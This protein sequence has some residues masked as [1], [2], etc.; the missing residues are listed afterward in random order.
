MVIRNSEDIPDRWSLE[1]V[2]AR[3]H[4]SRV[5]MS[6]PKYFEVRDIKNEFMRGQLGRVDRNAAYAQ[7]NEMRRTFE[8]CGVSCDTVAALPGCE[9]MVFT[10]NPSFNGRTADGRQ[11][12]VLSRMAFPSRAPEVAAHREW[13]EGHGYTIAEMPPEVQ[14]FE[15]GGDAV[16]HPGRALIWVGAGQRTDPRA[17][18]ALAE[19]FDASVVSL[20]LVDSRFYHLD[21]CFCALSERCALIYPKAF[22]PEGRALIARL[23]ED[24]I[25]ID[26]DEATRAFACNATA[27]HG[28]VVVMQSGATRTA[29]AVRQRGF[30]VVEV[31]TGE[32]LKSGGSV[33]CMKA[34]LF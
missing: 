5:L 31:E 14:R 18:Q 25:E 29:D 2:P 30:E 24:V 4:A 21:T 7:W 20:E 12:S 32:F 13:F 17:H 8:R 9:D 23:F 22:A 16:W 19:I 3:Q 28:R 10:A 11:V 27:F 34:F 26:E 1:S 15:G 6:E 33:Y